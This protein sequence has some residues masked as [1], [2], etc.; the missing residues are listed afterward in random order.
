MLL[1]AT[2]VWKSHGGIQRYMR[3]IARI[4]A[5][6]GEPFAVLSLLDDD[7]HR[8]A[9]AAYC[10]TCGG[11]KWRFCLDAF[12]LA[13]RG[14]ARGIIVGHVGLLP[15]A[16]I[17][18]RM[19]VIG[20]Y[21]VVLHGI[22]AWRRHSWITRIAARGA[23]QIV[24]T[25]FYT[26]REFCFL[27]DLDIARCSVIP[28]AADHYD[29]MGQPHAPTGELKLL[30]VSRMTTEDGYKGIDTLLRSV[31]LGLDSGLALSVDLVGAGND[32]DRLESLARS[33]NVCDAVRF[34]GAV[35]DEELRRLYREAHVFVLPS[36]NEGFGIVFLEAMTAGLP[37]IGAN[38]GGTPEVIKHGETG[39]LIEY[40]DAE[41]LVTYLRAIVES[42]DLYYSLS[43]AARRW[44]T[45]TL[46]FNAMYKSWSGL[47]DALK[48]PG[49]K[50]TDAP[51]SSG[52]VIAAAAPG[53]AQAAGRGVIRMGNLGEVTAPG[54]SVVRELHQG[55]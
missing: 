39:F 33:L 22:E 27:N 1:L 48:P 15:V 30:S 51:G 21:A 19:N 42:P 45:E 55:Y 29:S 18:R 34:R 17:L 37:C 11:G 53:S 40:G 8:P 13:F 28:L 50:V 49:N 35:P 32:T 26:A 52:A 9:D 12:R 10:T 5:D 43:R 6:R 16:W 44:A 25:T 36:K 23:S 4:F 24:A 7:D 3:I 46:G 38:H 41:Q 31:R 14:M 54:E 2:E 47:I 20:R